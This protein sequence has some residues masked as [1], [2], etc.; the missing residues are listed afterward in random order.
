VADRIVAIIQARMTSTRLPEK[1]LKPLAGVPLIGHTV[2]RVSRI[3][4]V[5]RVVV[6]LAEGPAHD[7]VCDVLRGF[8]VAIVRGSEG[9]VLARTAA[10]ARAAAADVIMRITSDCPVVDPAVSASVLAAFR[11]V[12][13]TGIR[14][15]RTAIEDGF[16]LGFD[17]EVLSAAA[18]YEAD[19]AAADP[20]EREHVTPYI[21]RRPDL[22]PALLLSS[23]P[24]CRA[25]RL[26]VDTEEDYR[27]MGSIFD[28][29]YK[30]NPNFGF[31]DLKLLFAARPELL[32]VNAHV[33]GPSY[34]GLA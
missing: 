29:L 8:D 30:T 17:T 12:R 6:A 5:D 21:W 4:G 34:V 11:A 28:A 24:D 7:A 19:A 2:A 22:Y 27:L 25:W 18:L 26:V 32:A 20:Y 33:P 31:E 14:Y 16:P 23:K 1:V 9:D 13:S 10:A 15:A 3:A